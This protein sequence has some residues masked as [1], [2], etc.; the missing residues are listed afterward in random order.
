MPN[1]LKIGTI[2]P[3]CHL[4]H[5]EYTKQK[6]IVDASNNN[7][8]ELA[9]YLYYQYVLPNGMVYRALNAP[10]CVFIQWNG[11]KEPHA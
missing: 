8:L 6:T 3:T 10:M 11:A 4:D 5:L 9:K 1:I 2:S 7:G